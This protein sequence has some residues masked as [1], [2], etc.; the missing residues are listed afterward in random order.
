MVAVDTSSMVAYLGGDRGTDVDRVQAALFADRLVLPPPVFAELVS[1]PGL[2]AAVIDDLRALRT[3]PIAPGYW[4]RVGRLRAAVLGK[5]R[6]ARLGDALIAQ[7]CMD[8]DLPLITRDKDFKHFA[9]AGGLTLV[10]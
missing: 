5:G 8:Y 2:S 1:A 10:E 3:H 9:A 4:E 6:R 7:Y